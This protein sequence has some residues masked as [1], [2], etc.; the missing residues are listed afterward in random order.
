MLL[1]GFSLLFSLFLV[2][3]VFEIF[4]A[5]PA[6]L[7]LTSIHYYALKERYL[8]DPALVLKMKP[9]Y[10]YRGYFPGDI[11]GLMT[12]S[13]YKPQPYS[14]DY[15]KNGFRNA[16]PEGKADVIVLGD[17]YMEVGLSNDDT[18]AAHLE[19]VSGLPV[20]NYGM[21]WYGPFQYL[22]VLKRYGLQ[23]QPRA[24]IFSFFEGNDL[25]DT[26]DYMSRETSGGY[27]EFNRYSGNFFLRFYLCLRDTAKKIV[28]FLARRWDP[29]GAEINL[30]GNL[31]HSVFVYPVDTR[32]QSELESSPEIQNLDG[33]L[34]EFKETCA[35]KN[36]LPVILFIPSTAHVYLPHAQAPGISKTSIELQKERRGEVEKTIE[37]AARKNGISW[38]S[39]TPAFEKAAADGKFV[40]YETDTHWDTEG[41]K[42]AAREVSDF[43]KKTLNS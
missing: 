18:F 32:T 29:R 33:I 7:G 14:A 2:F 40:Y 1:A 19:K 8:S 36:I 20:A 6:K 5:M 13:S 43:L 27:Y 41:R 34:K 39:L 21:G 24:A 42:I 9:F 15:D 28:K 16:R 17:S 3:T 23:H 35:A 4:P 11:A 25:R 10:S 26:R 22:E 12:Q 38:I 30:S 31:F 37:A